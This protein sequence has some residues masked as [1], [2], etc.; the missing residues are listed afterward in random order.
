MVHGLGQCSTRDHI[1]LHLIIQ[2]VLTIIEQLRPPKPLHPLF[3]I[4]L[5]FKMKTSLFLI[6]A[7][8][9]QIASAQYMEQPRQ[10]RAVRGL[11]SM[12]MAAA[13]AEKEDK[14]PS[15]KSESSAKAEKAESSAK[16]EK[17]V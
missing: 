6:A 14:E 3:Q 4:N 10:L 12:P 1:V 9:M 15:V 8:S 13:K 2:L 5:K 16:A 17:V 11:Q 7:V